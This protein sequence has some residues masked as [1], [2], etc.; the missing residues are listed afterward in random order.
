MKS[1]LWKKGLEKKEEK[2][3]EQSLN[4]K[5]LFNSVLFTLKDVKIKILTDPVA[6]KSGGIQEK[7]LEVYRHHH[8]PE[9]LL[10][11]IDLKRLFDRN[12]NVTEFQAELQN[13]FIPNYLQPGASNEL[14]GEGMR[15]DGKS[16]KDFINKIMNGQVQSF[17]DLTIK[18]TSGGEKHI[19]TAVYDYLMQSIGH[20]ATVREDLE[21]IDLSEY[22]KLKT[23]LEE[24]VR[25]QLALCDALDTLTKG[26][27][28][29]KECEIL[30]AVDR[31]L[32]DKRPTAIKAKEDMDK[33]TKDLLALNIELSNLLS[34]SHE[35][36]IKELQ[37][38]LF[39]LAER[40]DKIYL[41][42]HTP[43]LEN[44]TD[45]KKVAGAE[46]VLKT[47]DILKDTCVQLIKNLAE[48]A[49]ISSE[50]VQEAAEKMMLSSKA[51]YEDFLEAR[52][53]GIIWAELESTLTDMRDM[54][55]KQAISDKFGPAGVAM[56]QRL[57]RLKELEND[58]AKDHT[59]TTPRSG[60]QL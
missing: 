33:I 15:I 45:E 36:S 58:D 60:S 34:Q 27:M 56:E 37:S 2:T 7:V 20:D 1:G 5:E 38:E 19:V 42:C 40:V 39:K 48:P 31:G 12:L 49:S 3:A 14:N 11:L 8:T 25:S 55:T 10:F 43:L 59:P 32:L 46:D 17:D 24:R 4:M 28:K 23:E 30:P 22:L 52:S 16:M 44:A 41:A 13:T 53:S 18:D 21:K 9:S 35:K 57:S 26:F 47:L 51:A 54:L 29:L 50:D 6:L